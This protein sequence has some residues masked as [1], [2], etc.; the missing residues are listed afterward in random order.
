MPIVQSID[1]ARAELIGADGV[2]SAALDD[3]LARCG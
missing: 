2:A 3:A 1:T